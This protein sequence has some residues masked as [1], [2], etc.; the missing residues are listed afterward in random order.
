MR[1]SRFI[2]TTLC[3]ESLMSHSGCVSV[4]LQ[5]RTGSPNSELKGQ[6]WSLHFYI[7]NDL[8]WLMPD[9]PSLNIISHQ[10]FRSSKPILI[11][12]LLF[13]KPYW[14]IPKDRVPVFEVTLDATVQRVLKTMLATHSHRIWVIDLH[15]A[16]FGVVSMTDILAYLRSLIDTA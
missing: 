4:S 8:M 16:L 13:V 10:M 15:S 6:S 3:E 1:C 2:S 9:S 12:R 7:S 11:S 14:R 5:F